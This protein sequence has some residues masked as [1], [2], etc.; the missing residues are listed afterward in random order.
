[1]VPPL[2]QVAEPSEREREERRQTI[3]LSRILLDWR[4]RLKKNDER[5]TAATA[6]AATTTTA[7]GL[8]VK[9]QALSVSRRF[10]LVLPYRSCVAVLPSARSPS[11]TER[12]ADASIEEKERLLQLMGKTSRRRDN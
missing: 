5:R 9:L 10:F 11:A 8:L 1:M 4:R 6:T 7:G 12:S 2:V 3:G